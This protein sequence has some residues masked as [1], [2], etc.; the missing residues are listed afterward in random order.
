MHP[1]SLLEGERQTAESE[2][3]VAAF[4]S[5]QGL[6]LRTQRERE[7]ELVGQKEKDGSGEGRL[8]Q[9]LTRAGVQVAWIKR[10]LSVLVSPREVR[11]PCLPTPMAKTKQTCTTT[12]LLIWNN[13]K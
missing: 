12:L 8:V 10:C 1:R 5:T 9:E 7:R 4:M 6:A 3:I 13:G 11:H 2:N